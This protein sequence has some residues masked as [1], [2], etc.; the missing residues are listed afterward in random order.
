MVTYPGLLSKSKSHKAEG[1]YIKIKLFG[2]GV[3]AEGGDNLTLLTAA[4]RR[5]R[6][7]SDIRAQFT[8][9]QLPVP[10]S[11]TGLGSDFISGCD[12]TGWA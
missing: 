5:K 12:F 7:L 11:C 4:N 9:F 8:L 6:P 3:G 1:P 10:E 2:G